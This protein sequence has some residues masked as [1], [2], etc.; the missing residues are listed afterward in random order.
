LLGLAVGDREPAAVAGADDLPPLDP[1]DQAPGVGAGG[2][3]ALELS[4]GRLGD[5]DLLVRER[6]A[7]ADGDL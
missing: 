2:A 1:V 4:G 7:P 3:E 6:L 5:D